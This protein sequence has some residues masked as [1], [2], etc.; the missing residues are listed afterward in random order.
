MTLIVA[1]LGCT[2]EPEIVPSP[3]FFVETPQ[4]ESV[5]VV[6]AGGGAPVSAFVRTVNRYGAAVDAPDVDLE[7]DGAAR[8]VTIDALGYGELYWAPE[9]RAFV[10]GAAEVVTLDVVASRW[11][12]FGLM[13]AYPA[14]FEGAEISVALTE[15]V[16]VARGEEVWWI[17]TTG[18]P[19]RVLESESEILGLRGRDI[20]VDGILD[21]VAWS[22]DT[23]F[24]L[25]GRLGGGVAW[26]AAM[27]AAGYTVG[28]VDVQD[29]NV[30]NLPDLAIAWSQPESH[31][32][33]VWHGDGLWGFDA[34]EPRNLRSE[35]S[36]VCIGDNSGEG[37]A[38]ITVTHVDGTW[39]RFIDGRDGLYMPVGPQKPDK[40][41]MP[42]SPVMLP[43]A[44]MNGDE[45]D[46]LFAA[47]PYVVAE[48]REIFLFEMNSGVQVLP[49]EEN[50]AYIT[51]ADGNA[52]GLADLWFLPDDRKLTSL[53]FEKTGPRTG[54]YRPLDIIPLS[55]HAPITMSTFGRRDA[56]GDLF[57]AGNEL[58]WFIEGAT[59]AEDDVVDV[60]WLPGGPP[61]A[62]VG[63][64]F[65]PPLA[66]V[67]LDDDS[68]TNQFLIFWENEDIV[69][70][71]V[72]AQR[73]GESPVRAGGVLL[74]AE[75]ALASD[76]AVCGKEAFI[77]GQGRLI[78][79]SIDDPTR[80]EIRGDIPIDES[81]ARVDCGEGP[82]GAAV[83]ALDGDQIVL[84]DANLVEL[85]RS[86]AGSAGDVALVDLGSGP[87]V[88]TCDGEGCNVVGWPRADGTVVVA[89][90]TRDSLELVDRTGRVETVVG[91]GRLLVTDVDR[92][93]RLD[94][95][96][97]VSGGS[98]APTGALV[99]LH[100]ASSEGLV[101]P[102]I[103]HS[104]IE[105]RAD[106]VAVGD[107]DGDRQPDLWLI[108]PGTLLHHSL[109]PEEPAEIDR[110]VDTGQG[111]TG[112]TGVADT[113]GPLDTSP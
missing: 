83:V 94:L 23:V 1:L 52:D 109:A 56:V 90:S 63:A 97:V 93:G 3:A 16:A 38:Q 21:L 13:R 54:A 49:L 35:P 51:V 9:G 58:W 85:D 86:S 22:R 103:Y 79:V 68:S 110:V 29:L 45:A 41:A 95:L 39:S 7:V 70:L 74:W 75:G 99:V 44:D 91:G 98:E 87:E 111:H 57:L 4:A 11:P 10:T 55:E 78:R 30:D 62:T 32:L 27:Q 92:D 19:H 25:R 50:A 46:E 101:P 59:S 47:S 37:K 88:R 20:D 17:G 113:A 18:R 71:A 26:G 102:D 43:G 42:A 69:E 72:F 33:D 104:S 64:G 24:L 53:T 60:F 82:L 80:P 48:G 15:S 108:D 36:D 107:G 106:W 76:M 73:V 5:E 84:Y 31:V 6:P 67:D 8:R 112:D 66:R 14:P 81:R 12:G 96:A 77:T 61:Q 40:V 2:A 89:R 28:G 65:R 105:A 34:R 100:R